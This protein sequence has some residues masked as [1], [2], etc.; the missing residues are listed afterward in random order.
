MAWWHWRFFSPSISALAQRYPH[1][2][3]G[4]R[5]SCSSL[6]SFVGGMLFFRVLMPGRAP[7]WLALGHGS[8][9]SSASACSTWLHSRVEAFRTLSD[10]GATV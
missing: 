1:W 6:A 3:V 7:L 10:G 4:G 9:G 2:P 8:V 5:W